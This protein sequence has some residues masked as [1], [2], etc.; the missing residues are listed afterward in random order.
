MNKN[1]NTSTVK[2][3]FKLREE[4][5]NYF[6]YKED[7]VALPLEDSTSYVW[8]LDDD[9]VRFAET[10]EKLADEETG[11]YYANEIYRQ[12]FLDKW[13]YRADDYTMIV[14]DTHTDGNRFLQVFDN[15]K[16]VKS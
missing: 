9:E 4:V 16:E 14:V 11:D 10:R 12:R 13:V 3:Y 8:E 15:S 7:W 2:D 6:G 5:F 1:N